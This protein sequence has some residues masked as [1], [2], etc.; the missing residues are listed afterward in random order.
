[1]EIV[2]LVTLLFILIFA[3]TWILVPAFYG[4]PSVPTRPDRIRAALRLADLRPGEAFF[5]LGAGDGRTLVIAAREFGAKATGIEVG[6]AQCL[7][8]WVNAWASGVRPGARAERSRSIRVK[9]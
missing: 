3:L 9:R 7:V 6:P 4:L 8:A 5:D 2:A 1:M